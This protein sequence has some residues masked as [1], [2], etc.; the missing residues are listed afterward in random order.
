MW[1]EPFDQDFVGVPDRPGLLDILDH[2]PPG[3][4]LG[5]ALVSVD[6]RELNGHDLVKLMQARL[7]QISMLQAELYADMTELA[8]CPPG[9][10][11]SPPQRQPE[12][13][14]FAAD[15]VRA[16]L[17]WTRRAADSQLSLAHI[18]TERLPEVWDALRN[19][20]IDLPRAKVI[21]YGTEHLDTQIAREIAARILPKA[22]GLTT[23]QLRARLRRLCIEAHPDDAAERYRRGV[24]E[25][26]VE[27]RSNPDGTANLLGLDLPADRVAAIT[28]RIT[29]L[30]RRLKTAT[31]ARSVDQL[32]ADV[33]M[34]LLEGHSP[35]DSHR[36]PVVDIRVDLPT[37][38]GL[39]DNAGEIPGW[40]PVIA[41]IARQAVERQPNGEWRVVVTDP[42]SGNVL[43]DGTTRRRPTDLQRRWVEAR[44]PTCTFPGCRHPARRSDMDHTLDVND[45]GP[46][47]VGN[48][49]PA[50]RHDHRLKHEGG[51]NLTQPQPGTYI[52]TSPH[53][54]TYVTGRAPP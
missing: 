35:R 24:R 19:G 33:F 50:C 13:E 27:G 16:A 51:W 46:T 11:N 38:M 2:V 23:G 40:G 49:E 52:W 15:E 29:L 39:D 5:H 7:R 43:W 4:T 10:P 12:P 48:L 54:H 22:G 45:D 6:R 34:D 31:E 9:T 26:R 17:T 37:L 32:R 14:E 28:E 47:I 44:Q 18:L 3:A 20:H 25:R 8:H 53:G 21:A 41:D 1:E 36:A 30:A 42:D